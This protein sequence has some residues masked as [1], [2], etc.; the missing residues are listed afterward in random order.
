MVHELKILPEWFEQVITGAKRFECRKNDRNYQIGDVLILKEWDMT[1][2]GKFT[3]VR[4]FSIL[5]DE[6][7]TQ[8]NY[9]IM[10]IEVIK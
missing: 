1:F 7:Y 8:P 9:I 4:V 6:Q 5:S 3:R 10:S 2:T